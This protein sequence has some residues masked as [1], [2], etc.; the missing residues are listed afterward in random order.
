MK[1]FNIAIFTFIF[2]VVLLTSAFAQ[3][4]QITQ[5]RALE[6]ARNFLTAMNSESGVL[7]HAFTVTRN[8]RL[9]WDIE[10]WSGSIEYEFYID[11]F[12][13]AIINFEMEVHDFPLGTPPSPGATPMAQNPHVGQQRSPQH[14]LNISAASAHQIALE[15]VG[16]GV[17]RESGLGFYQG[18]SVHQ[19][20]IESGVRR[21]QVF[22]TTDTGE[23]VR[24]R[25]R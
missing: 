14:P 22:V 8:N 18:H 2:S 11:A 6:V 21:F 9:V 25:S 19:L 24:L 13:G 23:I 4:Q 7:V 15:L 5:Q 1:K 20:A 17:V 16:G 3:S 12:T 10:F